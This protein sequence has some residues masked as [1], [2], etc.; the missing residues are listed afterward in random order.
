MPRFYNRSKTPL[1]LSLPGKRSTSVPP[2]SWVDLSEEDAGCEAVSKALKKKMLLRAK[3]DKPAPA[4]EVVKSKKP[5]RPNKPTMVETIVKEAPKAE[6]KAE[7][8]V[9]EIKE[10]KRSSRKSSSRKS[11][12]QTDQ[13]G[14]RSSE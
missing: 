1:A 9:E 10:D 13:T 14:R 5:V 11:T 7:P 8:K 6:V 4:K 3:N 2:K 12:K